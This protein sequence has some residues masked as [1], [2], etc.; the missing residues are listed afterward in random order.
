MEPKF[1]LEAGEFSPNAGHTSTP[2]FWKTDLYFT[3]RCS[4]FYY[5]DEQLPG[6][7]YVKHAPDQ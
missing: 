7:L 6:S 1:Q 2:C 4:Y 3:L 5:Q